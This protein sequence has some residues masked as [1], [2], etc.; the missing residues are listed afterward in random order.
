M[1]SVAASTMTLVRRR[2]RIAATMAAIALLA[3]AALLIASSV[4]RATSG[5]SPYT[6][7]AAVDTDPAAN[8]FETTLVSQEST[9][10]IGGGVM[11]RT[12]TYNGTIPGPT[13]RLKVG[14]TVIVHYR[15]DLTHPSAVHWHGIE[16]SNAM[17]GTPFTQNQ[18]APGGEFLYKFKVERPGIF[19]Y[20]PHHHASTNQV[21]KGL[22][23][24][25]L[26]EDPNEAALIASG[27]LPP[28]SQ[29]RPLVLSDLTVCKAPGANDAQ[30]YPTGA[31]VPWSGGA[32]LSTVQPAPWPV[33]LCQSP[34]AIDEDGALRASFAAGDVP[35]TQSLATSGRTN[36]GQTVLTNGMNVGARAGSPTSPGALAAGARVL[37]VQSGQG[38]RLPLVNAA[39]TRYFRLRLTT[40]TGLMVPLVRVGGE[41]GL[42]DEARVEGTILPP[43]PGTLNFG[44]DFGEIL[45][46]PGSRADVVAAIPPGATGTL[47]LWTSDF[48]RTG[49]GFAN[50][51]TV[52]VMH[53]N[54]TGA[55][56]P[57][58]TISG[59]TNLRDATGDPVPTLG[60]PTASLL[61]PAVFA[62]IKLGSASQDVQLTQSGTSLGINGTLGTHDVPG[63]YANI[64]HLTSTRYAKVG[65]LLQ[66]TVTNVT[67]AHH[68]F[69]LHGF[70][71]QPVS[72][73]RPANPTFTWPYS[74]FRDNV[75]IPARYTLTFR[76]RLDER[77]LPDGATPGGANG[78]W[79]FHCHIFFHATNGML[80]ELVVLPSTSR[81]E[82]PLVNANAT[83]VAVTAG[84]IASA[85]GTYK[86]PDANPV[87][88]S[89]SRG[90]VTDTGAGTWSWS[91]TTTAA[92][93]SDRFV[94]ITATDSSGTKDQTAFELAVAQVPATPAIAL[95]P[96]AAT[97]P[98]GTS[99]AVTATVTGVA[100]LAGRTIRFT[101]GGTHSTSATAA[102]SATGT[103]AFS[104]AGTDVGNDTIG[105][106]LDA[107]ADGD[108][109][110]PGEP[111]A[112]ATKSWTFA[113]SGLDHFKC[114]SVTPTRTRS[115]TVTLTDQFA[116]RKATTGSRQS[117]CNPVSRNASKLSNRSAHLTCYATRD[118]VRTFGARR[119]RV[120]NAFGTKTVQVL[121]PVSLCAPS[122]KR[123]GTR[124]PAGTIPQAKLDHFRCYAVRSVD[125]K[126]TVKLRDQFGT[127]TTR[128]VALT[129]L[130]NPV[131]K[132]R[133][134]TTTKLKRP[135]AHLVCYS[136]RDTT[137]RRR[138]TV[139][140][141]FETARL[142]TG[143]SETLCLPSLKKAP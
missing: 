25:I 10:D 38:L 103:A 60:A 75:D 18:V 76:I 118:D 102:T 65:G 47:T 128:V 77:A 54:V 138:V 110:D 121:R 87:T 99:H 127:K 56:A 17:D 106:C 94:Y 78:R 122:L 63:D 28:A 40:N 124:R 82:K 48:A 69:H 112:T 6:L 33:T 31:G 72:L 37:N 22:Y 73:T 123:L 96:A 15:N 20:H 58:Y 23:G 134:R 2:P 7:P 105:A 71:I 64:P 39:T 97:N 136:I 51:P 92:D 50:I 90:T 8:V 35:N 61:N 135:R 53:L 100:P 41:G 85:T 66:L 131:T 45:L 68:P 9:V 133:G 107:N 117:L 24:M 114:Y 55:A 130:C 104:Y 59:G 70:S 113:L 46:P 83:K 19:W 14:D 67:D 12:Q 84:Q 140:N 21:Y 49:L 95:A 81:N 43:A 29:T 139:R 30:T 36:E 129:R 11:A 74:E 132:L 80:G 3:L 109:A 119:V 86:D 4:G 26:V 141:Q 111:A 13:F 115:R 32:F 126:R 142:R 120:S 89:A 137:R 108:C 62:P 27:T 42:L 5:D 57:A 1:G 88:L 34:T 143:R 44:Y 125:A 52:P 93:A 101:V 98:A 79:V 16:L 91:H 116:K